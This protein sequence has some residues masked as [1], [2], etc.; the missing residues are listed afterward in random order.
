MVPSLG[1]SSTF[2][3]SMSVTKAIT[4]KSGAQ[5]ANCEYVSS[6]RSSR[7]G[8]PRNAGSLGQSFQRIDT[9]APVRRRGDA[10]HLFACLQQAFQHRLAKGC[11][12]NE[13]DTHVGNSPVQVSNSPS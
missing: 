1:S 13:D 4:P 11:L 10:H 7:V 9:I 5:P 2:S 8:K 6:L 12:T 3:G